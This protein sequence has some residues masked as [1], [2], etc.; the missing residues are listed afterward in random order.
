MEHI[1]PDEVFEDLTRCEKERTQK[2]ESYKKSRKV[3]LRIVEV[4][5]EQGV[6]YS[7]FLQALEIAKGIGANQS[8][9]H[10]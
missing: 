7:E 5:A 2:S 1:S 8:V 4:S 10:C 3:A 6:S 9:L